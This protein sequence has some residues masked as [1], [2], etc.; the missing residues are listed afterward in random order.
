MCVNNLPGK[1]VLMFPDLSPVTKWFTIF[2]SPINAQQTPGDPRKHCP[3]ESIFPDYKK[4][5][6]YLVIIADPPESGSGTNP[7]FCSEQNC[8]T[9]F[10]EPLYKSLLKS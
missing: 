9:A 6:N 1:F 8:S 10:L 4:T 2:S 5:E 3:A 7:I